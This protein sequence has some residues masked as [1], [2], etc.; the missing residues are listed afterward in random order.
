MDAPTIVARL[1][2]DEPTARRLAGA[3]GETLDAESTVC[4]AFE[5]GDGQW[6]AAVYFRAPPERALLEA[7]LE[8]A[9][10]G[11]TTRRRNSPSSACRRATG[12]RRTRRA[13]RRCAPAAISPS[14]LASSG[15]RPGRCH[16]SPH[17]RRH[18]L[19]QRRARDDAR[20]P[21]GARCAG[22]PAPFARVL[23]MGT[24]TGILAMAATKA[25]RGASRRPIST[26]SC[27]PFCA[28]KEISFPNST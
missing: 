5:G 3:L 13:F 18:R 21:A 14:R 27:A 25:F 8:L 10:V 17:R 20:L 6:Q 1:A 22:A 9:W 28:A 26:R 19:R 16:R 12:W 24:G 15:A 2:G 4:S 7:S 11:G 23:D